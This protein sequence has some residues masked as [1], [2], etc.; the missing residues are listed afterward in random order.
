MGDRAMRIVP[1]AVR[2]CRLAGVQF[3]NVCA[4]VA[5]ARAHFANVDARF[6]NMPALFANV[7]ARFAKM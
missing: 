3:A 2:G 4:R 6:A 1:L 5:Y 7:G